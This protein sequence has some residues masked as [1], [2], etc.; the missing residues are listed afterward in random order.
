M[1]H[2]KCQIIKNCQKIWETSGN[3]AH[4]FLILENDI[5]MILKVAQAYILIVYHKN[6]TFKKWYKKYQYPRKS[7]IMI[8]YI[9]YQWY[10]IFQCLPIQVVFYLC[11]VTTWK[12]F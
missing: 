12:Q 6:I 4:K 10:Y 5:I 11:W 1:Q 3:F 8:W 9:L 2:I 7:D